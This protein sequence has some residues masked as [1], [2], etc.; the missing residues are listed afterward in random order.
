MRVSESEQRLIDFYIGL[1]FEAK[2][3]ENYL[4]KRKLINDEGIS[5]YPAKKGEKS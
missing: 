3:I 1:R 5:V 4:K 2:E